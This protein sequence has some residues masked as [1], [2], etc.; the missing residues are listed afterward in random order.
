VIGD[1]LYIVEYDADTARY[2]QYLPIIEEMIRSMQ[3]ISSDTGVLDAPTVE[4]DISNDSFEL[5]E[6]NRTIG[7]VGGE[8]GGGGSNSTNDF[9]SAR[10][11]GSQVGGASGGDVRQ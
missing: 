11:G 9:L 8:G 5:D 4:D 2:D 7:A 1:K 3:L 10:G 6:G